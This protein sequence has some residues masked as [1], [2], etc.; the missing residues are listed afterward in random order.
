MYTCVCRL[1][2]RL[3]RFPIDRMAPTVVGLKL[4]LLNTVWENIE[5]SS[6]FSVTDELFVSQRDFNSVGTI[7]IMGSFFQA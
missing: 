1:F 6:G 3:P 5:K 4:V 2:S 7:V